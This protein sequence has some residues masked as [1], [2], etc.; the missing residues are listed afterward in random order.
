[1][2]DYHEGVPVVSL[3]AL[4][5]DDTAAIAK[6]VVE[7]LAFSLAEDPGPSAGEQRAD[8]LPLWRA[9][10]EAAV[11]SDGAAVAFVRHVLESWVLAQHAYW[12]V[13]RGMA[14]ARAG[15]KTLLR[16][17]VILDDGGWTLTPVKRGNPPAPTADRLRTMLSLM[18]ECG[19][20]APSSA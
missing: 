15:G 13:G 11:L 9:R 5:E 3:E 10:Q 7:G 18:T 2:I 12:S 1:M 19:L 16:L 4:R 14:D 17:R 20:L 6:A 8:R